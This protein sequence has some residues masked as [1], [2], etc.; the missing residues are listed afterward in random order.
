M[1]LGTIK[2]YVNEDITILYVLLN[3]SIESTKIYFKNLSS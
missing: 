2:T 1:H 3:S